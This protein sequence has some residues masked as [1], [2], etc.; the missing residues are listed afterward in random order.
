MTTGMTTAMTRVPSEAPTRPAARSEDR[1]ITS[2]GKALRLLTAFNS[3]TPPIGV[4]DLARLSGLPKSTAFRFLADLEEVGFVERDGSHYRLGISLFELGNRVPVCRP[5]GLR[6]SA[7]HTLSELHLRTGLS[8]HLGV[9]EGTDIVH[10]AKVNHSVQTLPGHL[11]PGSRRP[12][13][14]SALGKAILAFSGPDAVREVVEQGLARRTRYS[15]AGVP[16]LLRELT[17][18][19]ET[20]LAHENEESVLGLV[21]IAAPIMLDGRAVGAVGV[22][23]RA[24]STQLARVAGEVRNAARLISQRHSELLYATW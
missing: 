11:V 16:R 1:H 19:R 3:I 24:P 12:S 23:V 9:L 13:T 6:D 5:N 20:G 21:G 2:V 14:C 22:T 10:L 18:I 15:I 8:A 17:K 7:M 4:S